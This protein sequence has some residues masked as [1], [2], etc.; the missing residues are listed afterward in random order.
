[1]KFTTKITSP[2]IHVKVSIGWVSR[3]NR[4]LKK[5]QSKVDVNPVIEVFSTRPTISPITFWFVQFTL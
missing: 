4:L 5:R 1:M 2:K 3:V